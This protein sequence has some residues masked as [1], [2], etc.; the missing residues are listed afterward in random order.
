MKTW[1]QLRSLVTSL[2]RR[3]RIESSMADE[4][5]FHVDAYVD[6]L[7]RDGVPRPEAER[8]ARVEFGGAER[9]REECREALGLRWLDE[10][11][12][13][14]RYAARILRH[15]PS[16]SIV[17]I[18]S[19]GLGIGANTAIF[20]LVDRVMLRFLPVQQ[21]ER[22]FF[23]DDSGGKSEGSNAPPYSCYEI[24]RDNNHYL[25]EM[26]AFSSDRFKVTIDGRAEQINGQYASGTYFHLLGVGAIHGRVLTPA[27]DS[28]IGDGGPDGAVAVISYSLWR[29]R[30]EMSPSVLGKTILVGTKWVTIVGIT[31]GD[32]LHWTLRSDVV[33]GGSSYARNRNSDGRRRPAKH[34]DLDGSARNVRSNRYWPCF[35]HSRGTD[36][37]ALC[38]G[39]TLRTHTGRSGHNRVY[40][41]DS[42]WNCS[43]GRISPCDGRVESIR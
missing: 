13:D 1:V 6:D 4:I 38:K 3:K 27:D 37:Y 12:G 41:N 21:P 42:S 40:C 33:C 20:C 5:R 26:A 39:R 28:Q 29:R 32:G 18:L 19:L 9:V 36:V 2:W 23:I 43:G 31:A 16:F 15:S 14:L 11:A 34:G 30:F 24:L 25:S 8:R 22:L 17:A 35:R 7:V 10:L